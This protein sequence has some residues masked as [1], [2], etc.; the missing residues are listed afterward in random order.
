VNP[1]GVEIWK[2]G[3]S[4]HS[5]GLDT[6]VPPFDVTPRQIISAI[7]Q[8]AIDL[9]LPHPVHIH[10]NQLGV[11]GNWTTSLATMK[12][13]EGRRAHL[14]HIQFHSYGG[15]ADDQGTFCSHV[16]PL[17]DYVNSH[18]NISVDV[19]QVVFGET[20]SMTGDGPLG[21]YLHKVTGRKWFSSDTELEAGCGIV[22]IEYKDKSLI[23]AVQWA[24]G[25]EWYLLVDDPWRLAM[26][27]DHPNGGSFL[28]YPEIIALL[29]DRERRKEALARLPASIR[30]RTVLGDLDREYTLD[31]IA[32]ITRAAPAKILGLDRKGHLDVGADADV[33]IYNSN[34]DIQ[35]MFELPRYVIHAGEIVV[36][37]GEIRSTPNGRLLH[38]A[39]Q[40][41]ADVV[42]HI[43]D[44]FERC[45][46][47]Q[48]DNYPVDEHYLQ[49]HEIVPTG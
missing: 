18:P 44:W 36:E 46:T 38:V 8:T 27:T 2:G 20:T 48:F 17:A 30:E 11:P 12:A 14:T 33:T 1:G 37:D 39:P 4:G 7:A 9:G 34:S 10:C 47:I 23:H 24:V 19:G 25:L 28:A 6:N 40:F 15:G 5:T 43:R 32:I 29:M 3:D 16:Q 26:S 42:P 49:E 31:E 13:L 22:P 45:Y 35:R 21:Y 41:D